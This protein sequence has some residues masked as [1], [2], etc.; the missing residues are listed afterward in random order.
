MSIHTY[1]HTYEIDLNEN[2]SKNRRRQ[3]GQTIEKYIS[4]GK[5]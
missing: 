4:N 5:F 1:I 3:L 2:A